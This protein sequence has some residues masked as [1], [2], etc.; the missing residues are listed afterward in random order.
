MPTIEK[1][2]SLYFV[3]E[4]DTSEPWMVINEDNLP[5]VVGYLSPDEVVEARAEPYEPVKDVFDKFEF[6][7]DLTFQ[8][9]ASATPVAVEKPPTQAEVRYEFYVLNVQNH[10]DLMYGC[11]LLYTSPSPRDS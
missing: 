1:D 11:C 7:D 6:N 9:L 4:P 3:K 5:P 8:D 2:E 10:G